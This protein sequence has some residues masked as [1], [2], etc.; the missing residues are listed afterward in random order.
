VFISDS[1]EEESSLGAVNCYLPDDFVKCLTVEFFSDGTNPCFLGLPVFQHSIQVLGEFLN[2]LS[3]GGLV[4]DVLD[5]QFIVMVSPIP[6]RQNGVNDFWVE[7]NVH[8]NLG[9]VSLD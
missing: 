5:M 7:V 8:S 2:I 1:H 4:G 3:R 6:R 9:A